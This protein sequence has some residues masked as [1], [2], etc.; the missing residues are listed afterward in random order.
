MDLRPLRARGAQ[1]GTGSGV[2]GR[3]KKQGRAFRNDPKS[4][5]RPTLPFREPVPTLL[6]PG[7]VEKPRRDDGIRSRHAAARV[8]GLYKRSGQL[9]ANLRAG[10]T[11]TSTVARG[12]VTPTTKVEL[13]ATLSLG[14]GL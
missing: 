8:S 4:R 10:G 11:T 6:C 14:L 2:F 13:R 5:L 7:V 3:H 9:R 1:N 12:G